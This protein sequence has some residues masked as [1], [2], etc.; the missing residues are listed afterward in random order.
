MT[1]GKHAGALRTWREEGVGVDTHKQVSLHL[2][3]LLHPHMQGNKKIGVTRE[4]GAN[5]IAI[6]LACIDAIT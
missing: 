6:D 5:G 3:G 4:V 1:E 2:S